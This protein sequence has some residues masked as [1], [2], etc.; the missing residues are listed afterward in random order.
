V[1]GV[2]CE[3]LSY[4]HSLCTPLCVEQKWEVCV[5]RASTTSTLSALHCVWNRSERCVLWGPQLLALSLHCTVCG[6]EVRGVCCEGLSYKPSLCTPVSSPDSKHR[7]IF[8]LLL[9]SDFV[10]C[11]ISLVS[12]ALGYLPCLLNLPGLNMDSGVIPGIETGSPAQSESGRIFGVNQSKS[13]TSDERWLS[14]LLHLPANV[15]PSP[16]ATASLQLHSTLR[17]FNN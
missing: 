11:F 2:C 12:G 9:L 5:V 13:W 8:V 14:S 10:F 1:R 16:T 6:T 17:N 3:G 7:F 4:K 15:S